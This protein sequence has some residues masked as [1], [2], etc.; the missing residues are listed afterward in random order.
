MW[1]CHL[2]RSLMSA[3][4]RW[5]HVHDVGEGVGEIP[6]DGRWKSVEFIPEILEVAPDVDLAE[7]EEGNQLFHPALLA[8][9]R[10]ANLIRLQ[11][12]DGEE[13]VGLNHPLFQG[14]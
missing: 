10:V 1:P 2:R 4:H 11:L 3:H 12:L 6:V 9:L 14:V 13:G 7:L 8:P 5:D